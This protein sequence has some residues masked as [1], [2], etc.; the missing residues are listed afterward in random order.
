MSVLMRIGRGPG[1]LRRLLLVGRVERWFPGRRVASVFRTMYPVEH[2]GSTDLRG[3]TATGE[4]P[5]VVY[6]LKR[7]PSS[8]DNGAPE[9]AGTAS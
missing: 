3:A 4:M 8:V 5:G 1:W 6:V 7:R 9:S 2:V